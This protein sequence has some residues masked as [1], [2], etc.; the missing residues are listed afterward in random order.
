ML[1]LVRQLECSTAHDHHLLQSLV[2]GRLE[3]IVEAREGKMEGA[4]EQKLRPTT[5]NVKYSIG[6]IMKHKR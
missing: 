4:V 3:R 2:A 1:G 6:M 5:T